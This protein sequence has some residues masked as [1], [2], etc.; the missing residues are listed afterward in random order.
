MHCKI[1]AKPLIGL[2]PSQKWLTFSGLGITKKCQ[3]FLA[4]RRS[5]SL[6]LESLAGKRGASEYSVCGG[7]TIKALII[8][9]SSPPGGLPLGLKS[10]LFLDTQTHISLGS[11]IRCTK[12]LWFTFC[13]LNPWDI[14]GAHRNFW[15]QITLPANIWPLDTALIP[16]GFN[17][18]VK[19]N[20]SEPKIQQDWESGSEETYID[21]LHS[22]LPSLLFFPNTQSP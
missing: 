13:R 6:D 18:W 1:Y 20:Q 8:G 9:A 7:G 16:W 11:P 4:S 19:V 14:E 12:P 10:Y 21:P 2:V 17:L 22:I 3:S 5:K 15:S